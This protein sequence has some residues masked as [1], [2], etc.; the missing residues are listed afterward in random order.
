M[1]VAVVGAGWSGIATAAFLQEMGHDVN[2]L[3][4]TDR[5][6]GR[7]ATLDAS[8]CLIEQGPHGVLP[9]DPV[10]LR[11]LQLSGAPLVTGTPRAPRFVVH[12][13]RA[14]SLPT[15]PSEVL[16]TK[17]LSAAGKA[18]LLTEPFR[19]AGGGDESVEAFVRRRF[20]AA[21]LPL[22]DAMVT[23]VFAGDP[24]ALSLG[25]AFP[26]LAEMD[27]NGGVIRGMARG[28]DV[29]AA[30]TSG[31][32]GMGAIIE[33]LSAKLDISY[34][35]PVS[36]LQT[37]S[38]GSTITTPSGAER[39]DH[40]VV[41][42]DPAATHRLLDVP[43]APPAVAPVHVVAFAMD[44]RDGPPEGYGVLVPEA[45][46]MFILGAL[47][48]TRIFPGRAPTGEAL[49]RCLVG[50]RRHPERASLSEDQIS[51]AA[52]RD[53]LALRLVTGKPL[54][55]FHLATLGIPQPELGH[56]AWMR[57]IHRSHVDVVGIGQP[58]VGLDALAAHAFSVARRIT[59]N[60]D[61]SSRT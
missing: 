13:G 12:R 34:A 21:A 39:F 8:G 27:G 57:A 58:A 42:L 20:G 10:T 24:R 19:R 16:R 17:L 32:R 7:V 56:D 59:Q 22:A 55:T 40:V 36:R 31:R 26:R 49:V 45:E 47:F 9:R 3:E 18:R 2:V 28:G 37:S 4:R 54:R 30:L 1:R 23:G 33:G 43:I 35:S 48:E 11:L 5:A 53:L 44:E 25:H 51:R 52:W 15:S 50:G 61:E 29:R 46:S 60:H 6:G 41:A 14:V 38:S